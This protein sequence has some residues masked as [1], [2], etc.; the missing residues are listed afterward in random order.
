LTADKMT[1]PTVPLPG[2]TERSWRNPDEAEWIVVRER[3]QA[4]SGPSSS[5]AAHGIRRTST[6]AVPGQA[7]GSSPGNRAG[8]CRFGWLEI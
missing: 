6:P 4:K 7:G 8:R 2:G 3:P 5:L 1:D